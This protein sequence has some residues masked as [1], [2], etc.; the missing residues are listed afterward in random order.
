ARLAA[1]GHERIAFIGG[2]ASMGVRQDRLAGFSDGLAAAQLALDASLVIESPPTKDG[3]F[4]AMTALLA[5]PDPSTAVLC[6]NDVVAIGAMFALT[7]QNL[8]PG[9]DM[10]V[11][12]FDDI[13]EARHTTPALTTISVAAGDLGER[14]GQVLLRQIESAGGPETYLGAARLVVRE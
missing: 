12:G 2:I 6:F 9:R 8:A 13:N 10:A 1:L 5:R 7:R 4:N 14:A 11:I 3:G